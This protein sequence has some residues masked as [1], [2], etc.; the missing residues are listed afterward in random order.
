MPNDPKLGGWLPT[1]E[2]VKAKY[3][4]PQRWSIQIVALRP[5]SYDVAGAFL[6]YVSHGFPIIAYNFPDTLELLGALDTMSKALGTNPNK[7][8]LEDLAAQIL[9]AND[10]GHMDK[11]W[12]YLDQAIKLI[13]P[14]APSHA[15]A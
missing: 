10:S 4:N 5:E 7:D 12:A 15:T 1:A 11:A 9:D 3:P 13:Q 8:R 2:Q 14:G 6:Q